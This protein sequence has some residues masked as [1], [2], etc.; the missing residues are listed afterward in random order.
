[1]KKLVAHSQDHKPSAGV[2]ANAQTAEMCGS[3]E[4]ETHCVS[5]MKD[6]GHDPKHAR[7][8]KRMNDR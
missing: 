6:V 2:L 5:L 8:L 4:F 3:D 1:M 7:P